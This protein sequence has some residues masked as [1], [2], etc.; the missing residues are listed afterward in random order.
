MVNIPAFPSPVIT[1]KQNVIYNNVRIV[2]ILVTVVIR[3]CT[4][5][6]FS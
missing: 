1:N 6:Y 4:A 5:R 3:L 2:S